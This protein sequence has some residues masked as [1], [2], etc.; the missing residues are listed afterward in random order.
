[1]VVVI[2]AH[3]CEPVDSIVTSTSSPASWGELMTEIARRE[4][5]GLVGGELLLADHT[6]V[7]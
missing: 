6:L 4:V 1:L 3:T 5:A 2:I 7:S